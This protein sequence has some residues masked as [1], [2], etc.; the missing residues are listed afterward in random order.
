MDNRAAAE[1]SISYRIALV[2]LQDVIIHSFYERS[3]SPVPVGEP[4]WRVNVKTKQGLYYPTS[5]V[6]C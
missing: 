5:L 1:E 2:T 6:P 4:A 3:S